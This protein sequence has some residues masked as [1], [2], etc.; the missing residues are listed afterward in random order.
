MSRMIAGVDCG[1]GPYSGIHV[2]SRDRFVSD[3]E[4]RHALAQIDSYGFVGLTEEFSLSVCLWHVR[5][6]GPCVA[7][8]FL[9][10]RKGRHNVNGTRGYDA[11]VISVEAKSHLK[12]D[13][14]VYAKAKTRFWQDVQLYGI[15]PEKCAK[16]CPDGFKLEETTKSL[17]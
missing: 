2:A 1:Q 12:R 9:N 6:G 3:A 14:E 8:E 4:H 13:R 17:F 11:S 15:S 5:F 7:V 16:V 10:Q